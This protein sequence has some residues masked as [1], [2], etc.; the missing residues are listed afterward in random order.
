MLT[1]PETFFIMA[2]AIGTAWVW[3]HG[4]CGSAVTV[5]GARSLNLSNNCIRDDGGEELAGVLGAVPSTDSCQSLAHSSCHHIWDSGVRYPIYIGTG[6]YILGPSWHAVR[7]L[8]GPPPSGWLFGR[9]KGES[10]EWR[11]ICDK[12]ALTDNDGQH[13]R[14][15]EVEGPVEET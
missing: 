15:L 6:R 10:R 1:R 8:T 2:H 7:A 4:S 5:P 11:W 13:V 9:T 14:P 12:G 3:S